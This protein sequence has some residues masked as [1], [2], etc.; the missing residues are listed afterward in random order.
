MRSSGEKM[1]ERIVEAIDELTSENNRPPTNRELG[2]FL[3]GKSTGHID[4]HLRILKGQGV[5]NHDAKKS[6]GI[7]LAGRSRDEG[8]RVPL[9]GTIAAGQPIDAIAEAEDFVTLPS[10]VPAGSAPDGL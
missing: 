5:I 3:G 2:E 6:R 10:T 9:I 7:S 8:V 4:Y 1:R